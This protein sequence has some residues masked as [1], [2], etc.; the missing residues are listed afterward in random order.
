MYVRGQ[1][2]YLPGVHNGFSLSSADRAMLVN[3]QRCAAA[4]AGLHFLF[5]NLLSHCRLASCLPAC[6]NH[7]NNVYVLYY[8]QRGFTAYAQSACAINALSLAKANR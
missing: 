6:N 2:S 1:P 8:K 3:L 5:M 7:P 4:A